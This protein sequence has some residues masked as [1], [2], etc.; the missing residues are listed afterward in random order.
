MSALVPCSG[1]NRHVKSDKTTT[2]PFCQ[3]VVAPETPSPCTGRCVRPAPA[4]LVGAALVAAGAV[5][6]GAAC[7]SSQ[8]TSTFPPYGL[9]P[10]FDAGTPAD[11]GNGKTVDAGGQTDAG[12]DSG[13]AAK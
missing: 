7:E 9:P 2:C 13:E 3:A 4:R 8:S 1:C 5:L 10:H 6:S 11:S 12:P